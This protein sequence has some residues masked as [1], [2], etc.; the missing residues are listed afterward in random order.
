MPAMHFAQRQVVNADAVRPKAL[1]GLGYGGAGRRG[2]KKAL[3]EDR[4][5]DR[6][7]AKSK[8][9]QRAREEDMRSAGEP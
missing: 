5:N 8:V 7:E 4:A 6:A 9:R 1:C 2:E 3:S